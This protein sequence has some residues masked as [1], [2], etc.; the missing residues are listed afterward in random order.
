MILKQI[1]LFPDFLSHFLENR[2]QISIFDYL[3]CVLLCF[4]F[5]AQMYAI[6]N[7]KPQLYLLG[8]PLAFFIFIWDFIRTNYLLLSPGVKN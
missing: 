7:L 5:Y 3:P 1:L 6:E 8:Y 4:Y 2:S